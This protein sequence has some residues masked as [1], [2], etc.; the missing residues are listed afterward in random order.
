MYGGR[1]MIRYRLY[2]ENEG[3]KEN[4][5]SDSTNDSAKVSEKVKG[6]RN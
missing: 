4:D 3:Q 6:K 1:K 5:E 2:T